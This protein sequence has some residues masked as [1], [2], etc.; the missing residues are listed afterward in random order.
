MVGGRGLGWELGALAA[1]K[2][3][4]TLTGRFEYDFLKGSKDVNNDC[5]LE[6]VGTTL[7]QGSGGYMVYDDY[8]DKCT[9]IVRDTLQ[10]TFMNLYTA[11][12]L[13]SFYKDLE[14]AYFTRASTTSC[15]AQQA[16]EAEEE[17]EDL[18]RLDIP[19]MGGIMLFH[20]TGVGVASLL[21]CLVHSSRGVLMRG[22]SACRSGS[23]PA[24]AEA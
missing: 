22:A 2:C 21:F 20:T 23:A 13:D 19:S 8:H 11:G 16:Q 5:K 6:V 17:P 7:R 18:R 4:V 12:I 1:K 24:A 14:K 15:A 3:D 10:V 9:V